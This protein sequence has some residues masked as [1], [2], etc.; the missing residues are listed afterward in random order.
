VPLVAPTSLR[1]QA[2]QALRA[3]IL[4]GELAAG[5]IYSAGTLAEQ[6]G[7]SATPVREALLDLA[8]AGLVEPVRNRGFRVL[9]I[10]DADLDEISELRRLLEVPAV[11]LIVDRASPE[12]LAALEPAV[13]E[14]E[15][16]AHA[17]EIPA[18]LVA[19]REFH[20]ALLRLARNER[21]V[22]VVANLRDQTRL[23]GLPRIVGERG[24]WEVAAE[25]R[26]LLE[27]LQARDTAGAQALMDVHIGHTRGTWAGRTEAPAPGGTV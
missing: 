20:L 1:E 27:M 11:A 8:S 6:F 9:A 22:E 18:F 4:G 23:I 26:P 13:T 12:E 3:S 5:H 24:L 10:A 14:M 19:D 2:R 7:V 21:L 15:R 25:H 17:E 16:L